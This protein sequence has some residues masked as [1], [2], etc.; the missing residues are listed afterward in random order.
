MTGMLI[1]YPSKH[2]QII[3]TSQTDAPRYRPTAPISRLLNNH[4]FTARVINVV[5]WKSEATGSSPFD[6]L[7]CG[8]SIVLRMK[9]TELQKEF[10]AV[11]QD[12]EFTMV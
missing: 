8:T 10:V 3:I 6:A 1:E 5:C 4:F 2:R 9:V 11:N 7:R 12:I